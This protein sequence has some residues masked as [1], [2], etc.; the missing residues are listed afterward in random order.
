MKKQ[1]YLQ[2]EVVHPDLVL[3]AGGAT[4]GVYDLEITITSVDA[5]PRSLTEINLGVLYQLF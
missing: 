4:P 1:A 5:L 2:M 3:P